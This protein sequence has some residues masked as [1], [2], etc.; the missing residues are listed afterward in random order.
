MQYWVSKAVKNWNS[1]ITKQ[2]S[3]RWVQ[4][5][6]LTKKQQE[7]GLRKTLSEGSEGFESYFLFFLFVNVE[8]QSEFHSMAYKAVTSCTFLTSHPVF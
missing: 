5:K 1:V 8:L 2:G 7:F 3:A 4:H 6:V